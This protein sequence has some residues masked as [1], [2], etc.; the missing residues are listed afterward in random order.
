MRSL[1]LLPLLAFASPCLAQTGAAQQNPAQN[2]QYDPKVLVQWRD[3]V[4]ANWEKAISQVDSLEAECHHYIKDKTFGTQQLYVGL[5]RY[6]K[7]TTDRKSQASLELKKVVN[8]KYDESQFKKYICS[9]NFFY[10]YVPELKVIRQHE[11]PPG[12]DEN[13]FTFIFGMKA[14]DAVE[15]YDISWIPPNPNDDNYHYLLIRPKNNQQRADFQEAQISIFKKDFMVR[16][17]QFLEPNGNEVTWDLPKVNTSVK[18]SP[19]DFQLPR[20][21]PAGWQVEVVRANRNTPAAQP[22]IRFGNGK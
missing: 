22:K 1:C 20:S 19:V 11:L 21:L 15:R 13:V 4:L 7:T 18:L 9:G 8:G 10:E 3:Y 14:K 2:P 6:L 17:L 16:R 12:V 5:A